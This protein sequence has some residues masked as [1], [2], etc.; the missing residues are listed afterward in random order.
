MEE[1]KQEALVAK[2]EQ[3]ILE[4]KEKEK[5]AQ[6]E[7]ED[8]LIRKAEDYKLTRA[9]KKEEIELPQ[10]ET[11]K[12]IKSVEDAKILEQLEKD[13]FYGVRHEES[14]QN[15]IE[16]LKQVETQKQTD[17]ESSKLSFA[18]NQATNMIKEQ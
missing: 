6:R 18:I 14:A 17:S 5:S 7:A 4:Q 10:K 15:E 9:E 16:K 11:T 3:E 12:P 13:D 8:A 1:K 2:K